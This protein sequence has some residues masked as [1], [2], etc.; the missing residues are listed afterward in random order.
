MADADWDNENEDDLI[1]DTD[2]EEDKEMFGGEGVS[3]NDF[4]L[5]LETDIEWVCRD[6]EEVAMLLEFELVR[7]LVIEDVIVR[8]TEFVLLRVVDGSVD[9][10][11]EG[12]AESS[13]LGVRQTVEL[14][15]NAET[16]FEALLK[17]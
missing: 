7:E 9:I 14:R 4:V 1:R 15:R 6:E 8:E 5:E 11:P 3:S 13:A 17:E 16:L 12:D 2:D 10:D